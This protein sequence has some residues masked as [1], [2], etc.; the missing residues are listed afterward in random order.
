M[1]ASGTFTLTDP[2]RGRLGSVER[3]RDKG[4]GSVKE[5]LGMLTDPSW[6]V[7]RSVVDALATLGEA[8]VEPLC[9][10]LRTRREDEARIAAAVDALSASRAASTDQAAARLA[11]DDNPA[12]AADA[13][14]VLGRRRS[15]AALPLLVKLTQHD[16]DNVA[17]AAIEALG[18]IGGR[19]AVEALIEAVGSGSFFRTFPAIDI[20]GRSG[21]P[22]V[23]EPL[24]QL[25]TNPNFLPEAARALGR[26]GERAAVRPLLQ[27]L[28][29]R[30]EA[31]V[32]VA[33]VA[34][35]DLRE[36]FAEKSGGSP[37]AID[38]LIRTHLGPEMVRRL[39]RV[40]ASADTPEVVAA[41]QLLGAT[42]YA[43]AAPLLTAKLDGPPTVAAA[44]AEAL[45]K[46][47]SQ[48]D[49]HLAQAIREG[50]S[51]RRKV[52]LP[53]VTRGWAALD[54]ANCL[55]DP[56]PEVRALACDTLA[57]LGN[58]RVAPRLF[59][60]LEDGNLRV[61]HSATAAIQALG[62]R[63]ARSLAATAAKSPSAVVRRAAVRILSYFGDSASLEPILTALDDAD[64]RVRE[65][66]LQGLPYL[67]D[68]RAFEALFEATR[69]PL[70]RTRAVAMRA[71]GHVPNANERVYSLLLKG[72]ADA[73]AWVR[74]YA[75][76]SLGRLA[77]SAAASHI[78]RLL[79]D[80]AGQVRVAAIEALSHFDSP[81]AHAALRAAATSDD[82]DVKRAALVGLGIPQRAEDLPVL[83][84]AAGSTDTPTRLMA[85]AAAASFP[86]PV[87]LG[88]LSSAASDADEQVRTTAIGL[89]AARGEPEATE[90]LVE[91]LPSEL[92]RERARAALLVASDGRIAGLLGALESSSDE[93]SPILLSILARIDRP[94]AR[95]ALLATIKLQN[96]AARK[97]AATALAAR[98]DAEALTALREAADNDP[99]QEVRQICALLLSE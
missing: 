15:A 72:L 34:L 84:A 52:L 57:R 50:T 76:Q 91:L 24:A 28:A 12:V 59:P 75:C 86:S 97:A 98:G 54:V 74:Y 19:A 9:E 38:E 81:E 94:E 2:E 58:P 63:E 5:L 79:G 80:E 83:L 40:M 7:R 44:A 77:Y 41:C 99:D 66:A 87:V 89:L 51:A 55:D 1:S 95:G 49:A 36:R 43:E 37:Q 65:T 30:A 71:L 4:A 32:R 35:A 53:V 3:L 90:V 29:A 61:V 27:L 26:S 14:Q 33:A 21:D 92:T 22:R 42:G 93:L 45:E 60:L 56:D 31:V 10:L 46:L 78:A 8:A 20:L 69:R 85:L 62:T 67:E 82:L 25:L 47:G 6:V 68:K 48:A 39:T 64:A 88:A 17:V 96:T 73:D 23:V 70:A 11:G 18:R 13:A 16:N